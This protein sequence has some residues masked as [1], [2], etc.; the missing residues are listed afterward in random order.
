MSM[1]NTTDKIGMNPALTRQSL[2][3]RVATLEKEL[4]AMKSRGEKRNW[5]RTV[6]MF[7]DN[8]GMKELFAEAMKLREADRRS[9]RRRRQKA[10]PARS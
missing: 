5:R 1:K 7:T 2:E 4:A 10:R 3:Q 6:G 8:P 9:A